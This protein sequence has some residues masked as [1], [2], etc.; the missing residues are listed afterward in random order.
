MAGRALLSGDAVLG[1]GSVFVF[2][3]PG[4][5][6]GYLAALDRLAALELDVICPGH[7][8]LVLDP[9]AKL[10]EYREHRLD[11]ERR[12]VEALD[13]G[14]RTARAAR[15][16]VD[17]RPRGAAPGGRRDAGRPPRQARGGGPAA[18]RGRAP[19]ALAAQRALAA[20]QGDVRLLREEDALVVGAAIA[21]AT[22]A[23]RASRA[24]ALRALAVRRAA[25][26]PPPSA[27]APP[28]TDSARSPPRSAG[29]DVVEAR[30]GD[31]LAQLGGV[32]VGNGPCIIAPASGPA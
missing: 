25:R 26:K 13:A 29:P 24:A 20:R 27:R 17:R 10:R 31:Q 28:A 21:A 14:L 12:L 32:P 22:S 9:A 1:R 19:A 16:R 15:P 23:T 2:P 8:P 3:D 6:R 4:A 18:R 5:L 7:G 30:A 11:R